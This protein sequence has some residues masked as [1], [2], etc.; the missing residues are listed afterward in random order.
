[1]EI[2]GTDTR[3]AKINLI[4]SVFLIAL[5]TSVTHLTEFQEKVQVARRLTP[6]IR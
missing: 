5:Q 1:M 3:G 6:V 2:T 4:R